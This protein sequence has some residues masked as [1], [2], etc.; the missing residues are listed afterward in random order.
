MTV[1]PP[2]DWVKTA[3]EP[4][5]Y[6]KLLVAPM[7]PLIRLP[8]PLTVNPALRV[9]PLIVMELHGKDLDTCCSR[10]RREYSGCCQRRFADCQEFRQYRCPYQRIGFRWRWYRFPQMWD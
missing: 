6:S 5:M 7:L 10:Y 4:E 9:P 2:P 8:V 1:F 3:V